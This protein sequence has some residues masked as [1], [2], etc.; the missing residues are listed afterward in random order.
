MTEVPTITCTILSG[1]EVQT[2]GD[3][4]LTLRMDV[5]GCRDWQNEWVI[6]RIF[7]VGNPV[8][9]F[10]HDQ[11]HEAELKRNAHEHTFPREYVERF[12]KKFLKGEGVLRRLKSALEKA[13]QEG[14]NREVR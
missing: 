9:W 6:T 10:V 2:N 8:L 5:Y 3:V 13:E 4:P 7:P 14:A 1:F 11:G 12:L